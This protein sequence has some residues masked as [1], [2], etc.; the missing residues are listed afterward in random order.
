MRAYLP[1]P[2]QPGGAVVKKSRDEKSWRDEGARDMR[3]IITYKHKDRRWTRDGTR[4]E[5]QLAITINCCSQSR[6]VEPDR[7]PE[8]LFGLHYLTEASAS[9]TGTVNLLFLTFQP[10]IISAHNPQYL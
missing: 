10:A 5:A 1:V 4:R 6:V 9:P 2:H 7:L 8:Q 3:I